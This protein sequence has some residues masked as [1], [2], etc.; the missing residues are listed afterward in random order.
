[1]GPLIALLALSIPAAPGQVARIRAHLEHVEAELRR[2]PD[3][4]LTAAQQRRRARLLDELRRY[5][6]G[7]RFPRNTFVDRASPVFVDRDGTRCAVAELI[8]ASGRADLVERIAAS[9][10]TA[11]VAELADDRELVMWLDEHGLTAA[12]AARIQPSYDPDPAEPGEPCSDSSMCG[13]GEPCSDHS[14]CLS[15]ICLEWQVGLGYCSG[16]CGQDGSCPV[17]AGEV[18]MTCDDDEPRPLC[19]Y[20]S[21]APGRTG[22]PCDEPPGCYQECLR[23][24]A[25]PTCT[26]YC[27]NVD[28]CPEGYDCR[29][30]QDTGGFTVCVP[31]AGRRCAVASGGGGPTALLLL[32]FVTARAL[33]GRRP[34]RAR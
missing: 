2:A 13:P 30:R 7:G 12:E 6:A 17:G 26:T 22:W 5:R 21:P 23:D 20:P 9:R 25:A 8:H 19:R 32:L 33:R 29:A 18:P 10:N 14:M 16:P 4:G 28:E 15:E 31:P 34:G 11:Y 24:E 27:T 3:A 1:V